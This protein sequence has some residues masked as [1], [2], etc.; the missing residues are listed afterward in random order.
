MSIGNDHDLTIWDMDTLKCTKRIEGTQYS[1]A[2]ALFVNNIYIV[3]YVDGMISTYHA[4]GN[5]SVQVKL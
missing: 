1:I 5:L 4:D 2:D 3:A